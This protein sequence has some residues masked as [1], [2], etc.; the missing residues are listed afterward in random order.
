MRI[1]ILG[2]G[3]MAQA[4]GGRW[5]AAGYDTMISSR[6]PAQHRS[7]AD[8]LGVQLGTY[9][10]AAAYGD[11]LLLAVHHAGVDAALAEAGSA[12]LGGKLLI[13]CSNAVRV[14]GLTLIR[15]LAGSVAQH[16][17]QLTGA[18]VVKA[19]NMCH[20]TVWAREST[21]G[22]EPLAVL[23]ATDDDNAGHTV[24][25]LITDL[26]CRP[27]HVGGLARAGYLEEAAALV[28]S[29]LT[30]GAPPDSVLQWTRAQPIAAGA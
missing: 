6:T 14:E 27:V 29:L 12:Q 23:Y 11:V 4:L 19:F 17:A 28:I 8:K 9:A 24:A 13:D 25:A 10:E 2:A 21:A 20:S 30:E 16:V 22:S 1:G 18:R 15:P 7:I 26:G 3:S 5:Q